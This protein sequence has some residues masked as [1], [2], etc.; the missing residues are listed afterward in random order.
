MELSF[1]AHLSEIPGGFLS[2]TTAF[3]RIAKKYGRKH[4]FML[5]SIFD[6]ES[7]TL[8]KRFSRLSIIACDPLL[9]ISS[10]GGKCFLSG[11]K[12]IVGEVAGNMQEYR[13]SGR[14][15]ILP[16]G[17]DPLHFLRDVI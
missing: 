17:K 13:K 8:A 10:K 12:K 2:P 9:V 6:P 14:A 16:K 7:T 11:E 1:K 15:F 4:S 5:E 3:L